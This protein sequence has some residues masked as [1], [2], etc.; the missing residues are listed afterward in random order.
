MT[1]D[2]DPESETRRINGEEVFVVYLDINRQPVAK[3]RAVSSMIHFLES[4]NCMFAVPVRPKPPESPR[5][6]RAR[7]IAERE[8]AEREKAESGETSK[9][10][11]SSEPGGTP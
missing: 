3:S 9:N 2:L 8:K 1:D 10:S 4:G 11:D 5:R 7:A 6:A